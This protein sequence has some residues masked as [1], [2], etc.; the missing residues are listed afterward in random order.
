M[1][2]ARYQAYTTGLFSG[3]LLDE[4]GDAIPLANINSLTL[5]LRDTM[6][7]SAINSRS[8]QNV[9]NSNN[10]TVNN[11]TG[12]VNWSIQVGDTTPASTLTTYREHV[13][14]FTCTYETTKVLKFIHRMRIITSLSL[15]T[16]EDVETYI[17]V[18]DAT[19]QPLIEMM[20]E[21]F[22]ARAEAECDRKFMR[23]ANEVEYFSPDGQ[24]NRFRVKRYPIESISEVIESPTGEWANAT[25]FDA[26]DY[27]YIAREGLIKIRNNLPEQGDQTLRITYTGG[28][29]R[30]A[31]GVPLDLRMACVRQCVFWL[32]RKRQL[33][34]N[35]VSIA[36]GGKEVIDPEMLDL[37]TDVTR[38]LNL[39][40]GI[41]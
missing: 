30:E 18:I 7:G 37:L 28:L 40:R 31:G 26:I 27:G 33:G 35:T 16:V 13:A 3:T 21:Q 19:E 32:M 2:F 5:T 39:Y 1:S 17:G 29:A 15:A 41:Y 14:E 24:S 9:L 6:T 11:T 36:R 22:T 34:V 23:V 10:V 12:A 4:D 20:L 25:A 8:A 38:V